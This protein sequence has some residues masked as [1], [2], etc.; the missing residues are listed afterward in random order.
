V[1]GECLW[2]ETTRNGELGKTLEKEKKKIA[3]I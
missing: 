2:A 3:L 1:K